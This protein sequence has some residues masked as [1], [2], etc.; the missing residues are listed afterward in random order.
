MQENNL[1]QSDLKDLMAEERK[2]QLMIKKY[3]PCKSVDL[4]NLL[5]DCRHVA[6]IDMR[7]EERF[8]QGFVRDSYN[9]ITDKKNSWLGTVEMLKNRS[10][11]ATDNEIKFGSKP[12]R[13][14]VMIPKT[15]SEAVYEE[16]FAAALDLCRHN[17]VQVDKVYM[18]V[19]SF[20]EFKEQFG[21]LCL[22]REI[23]EAAKAAGDARITCM[24]EVDPNRRKTIYCYS[25][26]PTIL[27]ETQLLVGTV[28]NLN[29]RVQLD[30]LRVKSMVKFEAMKIVKGEDNHENTTWTVAARDERPF[31]DIKL[32]AE[33]YI[34]FDGIFAAI[35]QLPPPRLLCCSDYKVSAIFAVAYLMNKNK[36]DFNK[37]SL[38]VFSKIGTTDVDK[39]V[40]SQVMSYQPG[41]KFKIIA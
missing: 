11:K 2:K 38:L 41:N 34:D 6:L 32:N 10:K 13:R 35:D 39:T 5:Q 21:Y 16:S 14:I 22:S 15:R 24:A 7:E 37:A 1:Q 26:F 12:I 36:I 19:D 30:D 9:L 3:L 33:K 20:E 4:Y 8:E 23:V 27:V 31:L 18:L 29:S 40:Y 17:E 28:F 25:R